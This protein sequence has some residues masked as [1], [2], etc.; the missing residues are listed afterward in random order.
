MHKTSCHQ[1]K[2]TFLVKILVFSLMCD[3]YFWRSQIA[4]SELQISYAKLAELVAEK[5]PPKYELVDQ[6]LF[7]IYCAIHPN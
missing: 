3:F 1:Q 5:P 2:P 7:F 6:S 4:Y